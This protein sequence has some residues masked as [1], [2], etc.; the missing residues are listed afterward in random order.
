LAIACFGR[1]YLAAL[2]DIGQH[3]RDLVGRYK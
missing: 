3:Y 1:E 2:R